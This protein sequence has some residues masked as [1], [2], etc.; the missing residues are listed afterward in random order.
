[1]KNISL[2]SRATAQSTV[3]EAGK[4]ARI[5]ASYELV[6]KKGTI[7]H[8]PDG[9]TKSQKHW[10]THILQLEVNVE[11]KAFHLAVSPVPSRK[12]FATVEQLG[13]EMNELREN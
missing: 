11:H 7:G 8:H 9:K 12:A 5:R 13:E 6:L 2:P 3:A 4:L 1:M 10:E